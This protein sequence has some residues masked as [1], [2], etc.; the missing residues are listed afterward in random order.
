MYVH[1][2]TAESDGFTPTG[3]GD[4]EIGYPALKRSRLAV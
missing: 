2:L 1:Q 3:G 4:E